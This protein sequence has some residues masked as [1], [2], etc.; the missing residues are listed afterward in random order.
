[1]CSLLSVGSPFTPLGLLACLLWQTE[2][3]WWEWAERCCSLLLSFALAAPARALS[4]PSGPCETM[5]ISA[6]WLCQAWL[7]QLP[8]TSW[9]QRKHLAVFPCQVGMWE[10]HQILS[11]CS[12]QP[13]CFVAIFLH[14]ASWGPRSFL[15]ARRKRSSSVRFPKHIYG[16]EKPS[17]PLGPGLGVGSGE[18]DPYV[19]WTYICSGLSEAI[20]VC[21]CGPSIIIN[22]TLFYIRRCPCLEVKIYVVLLSTH[23]LIY[24]FPVQFSS[25]LFSNLMR[26]CISFWLGKHDFHHH[27][28]FFP[29]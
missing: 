21:A 22:S 19:G 7:S 13:P 8:L 27:L 24:L 15:Q 18:W 9:G 16:L 10:L 29:I 1:M 3:C 25:L 28:L 26:I 23:N 4:L 14:P 12:A 11:T 6:P 5:P 17:P 2:G 20:L